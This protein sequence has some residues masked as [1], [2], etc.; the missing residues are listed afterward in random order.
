MLALLFDY[1]GNVSFDFAGDGVGGEMEIGVGRNAE[2]HGAGSG[3]EIPITGRAGI[4]LDVDAAGR[5]LRFHIAG[6]AFDAD[7]AAGSGSFDAPAGFGDLRGTGKRADADI[8]F[9]I[10]NGDGA[11]GAVGA[12]IVADI[13]GANGTAERRELR[14]ALD[15]L[16]ANRAGGRFGFHRAAHVL[17]GLRAREYRGVDFGFVRDFNHIRDAE[18]A[19]AA[20]HLCADANGVAALFDGRVGDELADAFFWGV[21]AHAGCASLRVNVHLAVGAA[22]DGNVAG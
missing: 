8:A 7:R 3:L 11:G 18:I 16:H 5:R 9:D 6:G 15:V 12:E 21:E 22:G 13:V 20:A 14:F 10:G 17:N 4:A 2:V 19:H 1:H